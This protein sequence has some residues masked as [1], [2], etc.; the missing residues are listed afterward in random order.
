MYVV[1]L[2]H[3]LRVHTVR[4]MTPR[5]AG[6][7]ERHGDGDSDDGKRCSVAFTP[8]TKHTSHDGMQ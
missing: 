6:K 1:E 3:H 5:A 8:P 7:L 4:T 2:V